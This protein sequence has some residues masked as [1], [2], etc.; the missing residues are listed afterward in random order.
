MTT[1]SH[2][3]I[4]SLNGISSSLLHTSN[5]NNTTDNRR[6]DLNGDI[7]LS[8]PKSRQ[9]RIN[10]TNSHCE[11]NINF[12][13]VR[14][15]SYRSTGDYSRGLRLEYTNVSSVLSKT[16]RPRNIISRQRSHIN[17][18]TSFHE[19]YY[20][21]SSGINNENSNI[22]GST[23]QLTRLS[24]P[25]FDFTTNRKSSYP[26]KSNTFNLGLNNYYS[27]TNELRLREQLHRSETNIDKMKYMISK[28]LNIQ[29]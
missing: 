11:K 7:I 24:G 4:I 29:Q 22:G 13:P 19:E 2:L 21:M 26:N 20:D 6:T 3:V 18:K 9:T 17:S 16:P 1:A 8:A 23:Q 14:S 27:S 28:D 25:S 12:A 10:K 5:N 15:E